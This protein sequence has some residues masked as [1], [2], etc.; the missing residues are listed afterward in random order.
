MTK[1]RPSLHTAEWFVALAG[2]LGALKIF[3]AALPEPYAI[4]IPDAAVSALVNTIAF[5]VVLIGII[6][7]NLKKRK[8]EEI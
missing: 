8:D 7:T 6:R 5:A 3:L 4:R 2:F 1:M